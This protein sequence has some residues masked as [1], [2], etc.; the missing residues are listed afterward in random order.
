MRSPQYCRCGNLVAAGK[1][2]PCRNR[3]NSEEYGRRWDLLSRQYRE[4]HPLCKWCDDQ[5]R[6]TPSAH[7][8]HIVPISE[9]PLRKYDLGNL[10]ALCEQCHRAAHESPGSG[11][12]IKG[13]PVFMG[14]PQAQEATLTRS[15]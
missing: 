10:V 9:D 6:T 3:K 13:G 15:E 1:R 4:T 8:H 11:Q 12:T 5:G 7:V 14:H 2:C